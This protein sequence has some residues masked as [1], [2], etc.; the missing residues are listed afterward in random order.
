MI[1]RQKKILL[2]DDEVRKLSEESNQ[3]FI[4]TKILV[5]RGY[6]T[7]EKIQKFLPRF[8]QKACGCGRSPRLKVWSLEC[9]MW[10]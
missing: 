1:I 10:S 5:E 2:S 4:L 3:S 6:D 7:K 9:A 8:L